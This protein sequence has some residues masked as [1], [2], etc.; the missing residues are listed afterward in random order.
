MSVSAMLLLRKLFVLTIL[1]I[2]VVV[3]AFSKP[4]QVKV[5]SDWGKADR[6]D[7]QAVIDSVTNVISPYIGGRSLDEIIVRNDEKGPISLY[8]RGS[9]GEYIILLDVKDRYWA[10]LA[11]QF[12]HETCHLLTNYDL[13]P[14][15]VTRQQWF[16]ESL[17]EAFSLFTLK[18]LAEQWRQDAP[19]ANWTPYAAELQKYADNMLDQQHRS[20][21][22]DLRAWYRK[23]REV[24][25]D[26][27]YAHDRML[28]EKVATHLLKILQSRPQDWAAINYLNLGEDT[29]DHSLSKYLN[30]WYSNTPAEYRQT[31]AEIQQLLG[32]DTLKAQMDY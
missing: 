10:Q 24:L 14:N 11:Y 26:N 4:L 29:D 2:P 23:Q 30:D 25:E 32:V 3:S 28:N 27:P 16:E 6:R 13:A 15:N 18:R 7:V 8:E 17:C 20:F 12:A 5:E 31:V 1:L 21:A 9:Q 22:P 19:Y